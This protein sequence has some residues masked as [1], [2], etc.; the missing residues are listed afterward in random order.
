MKKQIAIISAGIF[1]AILLFAF[2]P[3]AR[4]QSGPEKQIEQA[5]AAYAE[6]SW[7]Q[8]ERL[9]AG[10]S[11]DGL[12]PVEAVWIQCRKTASRISNLLSDESRDNRE[13][14]NSRV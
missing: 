9:F 10:I 7:A 2:N 12:G 1:F 4:A 8:G 6:K 3:H 13:L 11:T 14:E 5:E